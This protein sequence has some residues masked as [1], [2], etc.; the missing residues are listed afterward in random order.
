MKQYSNDYEYLTA[1]LNEEIESVKEHL[2]GN[3]ASSI[4]EYRRLCGVVQG[5]NLAESIIKDLAERR[6]QDADE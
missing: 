4:E 1:R 2:A 6:E 3:N 5:L